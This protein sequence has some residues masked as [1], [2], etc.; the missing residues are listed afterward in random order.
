MKRNRSSAGLQWAWPVLAVM[1]FGMALAPRSAT[2]E[3]FDGI[4]EFDESG[5]GTQFKECRDKAWSDYNTCLVKAH[6]RAEE[7]ECFIAW[8]LDN[9]GCTIALGKALLFGSLFNKAT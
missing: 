4:E 5:P 2:A 1:L 8:D 6:D 9:L 3:V 7:I